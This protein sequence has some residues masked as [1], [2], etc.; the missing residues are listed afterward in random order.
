MMT[1]LF[2]RVLVCL[3]LL[4]GARQTWPLELQEILDNTMITPPARIGFREERHNKMLKEALVLTGYLEYLE[5]GRLRKVIETPFQEALLIEVDRIVIERDGKTRTLPLSKS[6]SLKTMLGGIEA[7][8]AGQTDRLLHVFSYELDGTDSA[9]S[10][11]LKPHS[12]RIARQLRALVVTG[13]YGSVTS[14]RFD[15]KDGEWHL[16]E[17][18]ESEP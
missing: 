7:I 3:V 12:R 6:R 8:L 4:A 15:L 16:M 10:M 9:W 2:L 14:I 5:K 11:V 1:R 18:L 17:I 13:N